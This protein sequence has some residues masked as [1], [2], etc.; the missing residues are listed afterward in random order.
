[1]TLLGEAIQPV[2]KLYNQA[3]INYPI[4]DTWCETE[5]LQAMLCDIYPV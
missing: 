3:L 4:V 1:M 5:P 2:T